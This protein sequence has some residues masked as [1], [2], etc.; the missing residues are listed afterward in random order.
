MADEKKILGLTPIKIH[1]KIPKA[2]RI[3]LN[4]ALAGDNFFSSS[5]ANLFSSISAS[6]LSF[7]INYTYNYL[8]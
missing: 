8:M 7:L 5:D 1:K 4:T 3:I 2:P 6:F